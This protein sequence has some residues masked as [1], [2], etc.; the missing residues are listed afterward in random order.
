VLVHEQLGDVLHLHFALH[1]VATKR[2][3]PLPREG[4]TTWP[5]PIAISKS[6]PTTGLDDVGG[7]EA[8]VWIGDHHLVVGE[9]L[10][11]AGE[12]IVALPGTPAT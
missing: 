10:F 6:A 7:S 3:Y 8:I 1:E 5:D 9:T 4:R 2:N 12:A 11:I